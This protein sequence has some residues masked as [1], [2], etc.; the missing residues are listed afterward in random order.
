MQKP[1][2]KVLVEKESD[3]YIVPVNYTKEEI[4]AIRIAKSNGTL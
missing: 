3:D 1:R 4:R 2:P